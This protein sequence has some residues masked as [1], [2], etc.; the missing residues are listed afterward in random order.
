MA[1]CNIL[2]DFVHLQG[3]HFTSREI[4][5]EKALVFGEGQQ[6][7]QLIQEWKNTIQNYSLRELQIAHAKLKLEV[8]AVETG[9][10]PRPF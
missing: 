3:N 8:M 10:S 2:L 4:K 5:I 6:P 9:N 1:I 7:K